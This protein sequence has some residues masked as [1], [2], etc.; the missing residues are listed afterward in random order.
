MTVAV[1][2]GLIVLLLAVEPH[3]SHWVVGAMPILVGL[4]LLV[5]AGIVWPRGN[6]NGGSRPA[7][8]PIP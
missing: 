6:G 5:S 3:E 2:L 7:T 4:A 1:G 8:P